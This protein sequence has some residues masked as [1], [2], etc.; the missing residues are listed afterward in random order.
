MSHIS[1]QFTTYY[2][3]LQAKSSNLNKPQKI[4]L[5]NIQCLK[6]KRIDEVNSKK[7]SAAIMA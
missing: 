6:P 2:K 4:T 7:F 3:Y 5:I 1:L